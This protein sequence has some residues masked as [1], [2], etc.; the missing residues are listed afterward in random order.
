MVT[1]ISDESRRSRE[2]VT[3]SWTLKEIEEVLRG[4]EE[5]RLCLRGVLLWGDR[6]ELLFPSLSL[7][8][9]SSTSLLSFF[10]SLL[11]IRTLVA[12]STTQEEMRK[13]ERKGKEREREVSSCVVRIE[14]RKR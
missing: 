6:S 5:R 11:S 7:C 12:C 8:P 10:S 2:G 14:N 1:T 3:L 13:S 4:E 9:S